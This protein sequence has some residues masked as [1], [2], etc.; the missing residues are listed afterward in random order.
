[1]LAGSWDG[2]IAQTG[3]WHPHDYSE[4]LLQEAMTREMCSSWVDAPLHPQPHIH[5]NFRIRALVSSYC[6]AGR[7]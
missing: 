7:D 2:A 5:R 1:M 3:Q 4:S 6:I